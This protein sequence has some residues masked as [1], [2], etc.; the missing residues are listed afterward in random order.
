M[1]IFGVE[2]DTEKMSLEELQ[3][4]RKETHDLLLAIELQLT[5]YGI[6]NKKNSSK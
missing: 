3:Q 2:I 4:L 1:K 6:A 5:L